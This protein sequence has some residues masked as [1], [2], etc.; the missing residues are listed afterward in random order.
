LEMLAELIVRYNQ[1]SS[2]LLAFF[3]C[4]PLWWLNWS[5]LLFSEIIFKFDTATISHFWWSW[6]FSQSMNSC[7]TKMHLWNDIFVESPR[8]FVSTLTEYCNQRV[9]RLVGIEPAWDQ[10]SPISPQHAP[11]TLWLQNVGYSRN[12]AAQ[13]RFPLVLSARQREREKVCV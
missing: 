3:W 11:T 13:I 6:N 8:K 1:L 12:E 4:T 7:V 5:V 10:T 9:T 2:S